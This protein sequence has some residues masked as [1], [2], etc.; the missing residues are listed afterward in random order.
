MH[1]RLSEGASIR[2]WAAA[3]AEAEAEAP[4]KLLPNCTWHFA[5]QTEIGPTNNIG[6]KPSPGPV[7]SGLPW[8]PWLLLLKWLNQQT[9]GRWRPGITRDLLLGACF[10]QAIIMAHLWAFTG[11][12]AAA[13]I[14][15]FE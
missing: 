15:V 4:S 2:D 10:D 14:S 8:L 11:S 5:A 12:S 3:A 13:P 1:M 9:A 7:D 6:F